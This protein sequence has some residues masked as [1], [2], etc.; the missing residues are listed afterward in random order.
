MREE[1]YEAIKNHDNDRTISL[2]RDGIPRTGYVT[3][4]FASPH[5]IGIFD[6]LENGNTIFHILA[7]YGMIK[8]IVPIVKEQFYS[9]KF[10]KREKL[11]LALQ[12]NASRAEEFL[13]QKILQQNDRGLLPI[14]LSV[15][16]DNK[17]DGEYIIEHYGISLDNLMISA[18]S[19]APESLEWLLKSDKMN[20]QAFEKIFSNFL[21]IEY[22][23]DK[24][25][26]LKNISIEKIA[27]SSESEICGVKNQI[28][29][30]LFNKKLIV[31]Y[32]INMISDITVS[33]AGVSEEVKESLPQT[34][35]TQEIHS[36]KSDSDKTLKINF[37]TLITKLRKKSTKEKD[38]SD[39]EMCIR[40]KCTN[41]KFD[42]IVTEYSFHDSDTVLEYGISSASK[43]SLFKSL[44]MSISY[45][46]SYI[47]KK[48]MM[49]GNFPLTTKE[50]LKRVVEKS[51]DLD[52]FKSIIPINEEIDW[53]EILFASIRYGRYKIIKEYINNF[54]LNSTIELEKT[55]DV[56]VTYTPVKYL[57]HSVKTLCT[58]NKKENEETTLK[59]FNKKIAEY[60]EC[61]RLIDNN[62]YNSMENKINALIEGDDYSVVTSNTIGSADSRTTTGSMKSMDTMR[63]LEEIRKIIHTTVEEM[64]SSLSGTTESS[65]MGI[66]TADDY[67]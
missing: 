37:D 56:F 34:T 59:Y 38:F 6:E 22:F 29:S 47:I 57:F 52:L 46:N 65:L 50:S 25:K 53:N 26:D 36:I 17:G 24:N 19:R 3:K 39:L 44:D 62:L 43:D 31:E 10:L 7:Q 20:S 4:L 67:S 51:G 32:K 16:T 45:R 27:T 15:M 9:I 28:A 23:Y 40:F 11:P 33:G 1:L 61:L 48:M 8:D 30:I 64:E 55:A 60:K 49:S 14:H 13:S 12:N 5:P 35:A 21:E 63:S 66:E 42:N 2:I 58:K 18:I 41:T 54:N